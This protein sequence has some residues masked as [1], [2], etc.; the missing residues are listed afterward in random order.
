VAAALAAIAAADAAR[1]DAEL[2]SI[3]ESFERRDQHL[4]D[5]PVADTAL[6]LECLAR[7]LGLAPA[8]PASPT[9][10]A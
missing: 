10:P 6:A 9:L 5:V 3:V 4:E 8:L 1:L 2:R 7:R